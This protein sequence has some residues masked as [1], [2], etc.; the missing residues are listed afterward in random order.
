MRNSLGERRLSSACG[1][2]GERFGKRG[3]AFERGILDDLVEQDG[4]VLGRAKDAA[5]ELL[6]LDRVAYATTKKRIRE[7]DIHRGLELFKDE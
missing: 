6:K 1:L 5:N 7:P 3:E 2:L 4:D